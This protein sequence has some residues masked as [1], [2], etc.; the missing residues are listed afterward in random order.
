[1]KF[2]KVAM[3]FIAVVFVTSSFFGYMLWDDHEPINDLG[4]ATHVDATIYNDLYTA[5][6]NEVRERLIATRK[7]LVTPALSLA[8]SIDGELIW[9]EAHGFADLANQRLVKLT[10]RFPIGSIS[11]TI[12][13]VAATQLAE[14]GALDLDKDI[15]AYVPLYPEQ[16]YPVTMRQ[17]LSHQAGI[18]H[19][20]MAMIPPTFSEMGL[21]KQFDT[22]NDSLSIFEN[23][24]LLFEPDTDFSYSSYGYTLASAVIEGASGE[25]FLTHLQNALFDPL[26]MNQTQANYSDR[27]VADRVFGYISRFSSTK[28]LPEPETNASNKWAGG[29]LLSTPTDLV[30]F[31]GALLKGELLQSETME[32]MFTPRKLSSGEIN[33]QHYGLG[34]RIGGMYHPRGTDNISTM[35]NHGGTSM[36]SISVLVLMPDSGLVLAMT[37]N[38]AGTQGSGSLM[39]EAAAIIGIFLNYMNTETALSSTG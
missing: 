22:V 35:I 24:E 38:T 9:A 19:Y 29:G 33:P 7:R 12:T 18:R 39:S 21:N 5:P 14:Q 36:G 13:A 25:D 32:I 10:T 1:M 16:K 27:P 11:K 28:V 37:A 17:L 15:H 20:N 23:D 30:I 3:S 34:W 31:G 2:V 6:I 4:E 26:K 8:V